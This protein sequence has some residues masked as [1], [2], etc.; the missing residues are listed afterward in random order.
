MNNQGMMGLELG[1]FIAFIGAIVF[2]LHVDL[3][4]AGNEK[5]KKADLQRIRY[6]GVLPWK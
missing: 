6:T 3:I 1:L 5:L 4:K 2:W